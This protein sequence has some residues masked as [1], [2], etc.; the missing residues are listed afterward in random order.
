MLRE[1][2]EI[3]L[4]Y[5]GET[6]H[7]KGCQSWE[8]MSEMVRE[9]LLEDEGYCALWN[10]FI[11]E[12]HMMTKQQIDNILRS[13]FKYILNK[14]NSGLSEKITI[15]ALTHYFSERLERNKRIELNN[16]GT[17]VRLLLK[18]EPETTDDAIVSSID[19]KFLKY[20]LLEYPNVYYRKVRDVRNWIASNKK[21]K[22]YL[23]SSNKIKKNTDKE[24]E[25]IERS[26]NMIA[27]MHLELIRC[28][29][30]YVRLKTKKYYFE[31][32]EY[33]KHEP[34]DF[35]SFVEELQGKELSPYS[36][37][38]TPVSPIKTPEDVLEQLS[39]LKI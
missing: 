10:L 25:M 14:A 39:S 28:F 31:Q 24:T 11:L 33:I 15:T 20:N 4:E 29:A 22:S 3:R 8:N 17:N 21:D 2:N 27:N 19:T 30:L 5:V 23:D 16:F 9:P 38:I 32:L 12:L 34:Y 36:R 18:M 1:M 37:D 35:E 6:C 13:I 26:I 7:K